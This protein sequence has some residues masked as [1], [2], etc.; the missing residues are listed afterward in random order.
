MPQERS[1]AVVLRGVDFSETSRIITF[2]CP[3]RGRMA[4]LAQ[5]ARRPQSPLSSALGTF[6]RL[7]IIYYWKDSR[8]VQKL[9]EA[10][11]LDRFPGLRADV[12]KAVYAAFP[13][14]IA[15]RTAQENEPSFELYDTLVAGLHSFDTWQHDA[16]WHTA[17]MTMQLLSVAGFSPQIVPDGAATGF[18]F[19]S[20]VTTSGEACDRR[21]SGGEHA[22]LVALAEAYEA[23]PPPEAGG[24][25]AFGLLRRFTM[26]QLEAE[27]RSLRVIDQMFGK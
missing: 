10:T 18:S 11:V 13:L 23:C 5:G 16:R 2:L 24:E 6:N 8:N 21:L 1:E 15:Y 27:F 7:E 19:D 26:R 22:A 4:C 3:E 20:G 9:G 14:E 17:W 12:E 25:A